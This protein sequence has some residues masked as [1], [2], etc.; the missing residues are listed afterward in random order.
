MPGI[1]VVTDSTA[2]IPDRLIQAW[3]IE[4]VPLSVDF[5]GERL[6]DGVEIEPRE[7]ISRLAQSAVLPT[8][9]HPPPA[10]F[11][12]RYRQLL[13][14]GATGIVSIHLSGKLSATVSAARAAATPADLAASV[15]VLD[16]KSVSLALGFCVLEAAR[17]AWAGLDLDG[18]VKAARQ[19]IGNVQLIFFADTLAYFQKGGQVGRPAAIAG[20][21]L[22][23]KPLLRVDEGVVVPHKRTRTRARA[24]DGLVRF[25]AD[26]PQL[27]QVAIVRSG[28]SSSDTLLERLG[29]HFPRERIIVAE[30]SPV[31]ASHLGPGALGVA[32]DAGE[33]APP[34]E[35]PT[36]S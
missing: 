31:I 4:V 20:T 5:D 10:E 7:F 8:T 24:I 12:A 3:N 22:A 26:F 19:A 35:L 15:T 14:A 2:D 9:A 32:V 30:V 25:V 1:R 18:V 17:A 21:L 27:R 11:E 23:L 29:E 33:G 34:P 6:R 13:A 16:S 36:A 28:E